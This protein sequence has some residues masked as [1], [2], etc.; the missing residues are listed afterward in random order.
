MFF[1][2]FYSC[3]VNC[4]HL[5]ITTDILSVSSRCVSGACPKVNSTSSYSWELF[6]RNVND[7]GV[8]KWAKVE[9]LETIALSNT[10]SR[11]LVLKPNVLMPEMFYVMRLWHRSF[12]HESLT[13]YSFTTSRAPHG[14][15]CSV[16]PF[17][18]RAYETVFTFGC[19]GWQTKHLPL[20]YVFS[21]YDPYT[22]LKPVLFRSEAE[23]FSVKLAPGDPTDKNFPL[24]IFFSVV[25]S[26]GAR[27]DEQKFIKVNASFP[28]LLISLLL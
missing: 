15:N 13:E 18:G 27:I 22:Q 26:L 5:V 19:S 12:A 20:V 2:Y 14:G 16:G 21:Y 17:Q 11:N 25:D 23:R 1:V 3:K 28:F 24:K 7:T 8:L 10:S 4:K 9:D 6:Y